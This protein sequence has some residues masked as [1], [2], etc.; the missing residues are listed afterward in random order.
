MHDETKMRGMGVVDTM[1]RVQE[2]LLRATSPAR[3]AASGS[4]LIGRQGC[5]AQHKSFATRHVL[6]K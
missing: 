1:G 3:Q 2:Y 6:S 4:M 5:M